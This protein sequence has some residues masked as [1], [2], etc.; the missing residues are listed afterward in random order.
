MIKRTDNIQEAMEKLAAL[1]T[2]Q[3]VLGGGLLTLGA[4]AGVHKMLRKRKRK[5]RKFGDPDTI[6]HKEI[7]KP[8][9]KRTAMERRSDAYTKSLKS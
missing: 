1:S 2:T 9:V 4:G 7:L 6:S 8:G 5:T 3:K